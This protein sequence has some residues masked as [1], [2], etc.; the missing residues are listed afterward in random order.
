MNYFEGLT[1]EEAKRL[2]AIWKSMDDADKEHFINQVAL[3]L[4]VLGDTKESRS[5]IAEA[6]KLLL[7]DGSTNLA[8]VGLYLETLL[9]QL[10]GK[11]GRKESHNLKRAILFVESYRLKYD[12]P[13]TPHKTLA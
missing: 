2:A 5:L 6:I 7:K 12:L 8:D 9:S 3:T 13:P 4:S 11:M 1:K 10:R